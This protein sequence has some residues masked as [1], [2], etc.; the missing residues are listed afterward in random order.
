MKLAADLMGLQVSDRTKSKWNSPLPRPDGGPPSITRD[1][2]GQLA[3]TL[4]TGSTTTPSLSLVVWG[5]GLAKQHLSDMWAGV[6]VMQ[7]LGSLWNCDALEFK[8]RSG[9]V[10]YWLN[11]FPVR[12]DDQDRRM[13]AETLGVSPAAKRQ[14]FST[15]A[16]SWC[17]Y[18][19][20]DA[21]G[22]D[23]LGI[24]LVGFAES[25]PRIAE[26][27]SGLGPVFAW[28]NR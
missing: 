21:S 20:D 4:R 27:F 7:S 16:T 25:G 26:M 12:D 14:Q 5:T 6:H 2:L 11:A 28:L 19:L 9:S 24:G 8:T 17:R 1:A 3:A 10:C 15:V 23:K 18:L 22:S 13:R